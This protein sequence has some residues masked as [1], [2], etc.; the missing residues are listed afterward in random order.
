M[1]LSVCGAE[2][3]AS[4]IQ[5]GI[6]GEVLGRAS[7]IQA[8]VLGEVLGRLTRQHAEDTRRLSLFSGCLTPAHRSDRLSAGDEPT[9]ALVVESP[10]RGGGNGMGSTARFHNG[11]IV[12]ASIVVIGSGV[13]VV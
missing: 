6:F 3:C 9:A 5:A 1:S 7:V 10:C 4:V 13:V 2:F 8:G 12:V 11:V